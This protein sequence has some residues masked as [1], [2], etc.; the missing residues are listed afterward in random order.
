MFSNVFIT[1]LNEALAL[2]VLGQARPPAQALGKV[3]GGGVL[4]LV[5]LVA[6]VAL[7]LV[8]AGFIGGGVWFTLLFPRLS[9]AALELYRERGK[10]CFFLGLLYVLVGALVAILL[11]ATQALAIF[12]FALMLL[13]GAMVVAGYGVGYCSA[14]QRLAG[15]ET[16]AQRPAPKT[17][18][19]GGLLAEATFLVPVLGQILSLGVLCRGVGAVGLAMLALRGGAR[20]V[21]ESGA[22]DGAA[23]PEDAPVAPETQQD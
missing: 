17:C 21:Q 2:A 7:V 11:V 23:R 5:L 15:P 19:M 1:A 8:K 10:K 4:A 3:L 9:G 6:L 14:G 12:G 20:S 16:V 13:L 22:D 18:F